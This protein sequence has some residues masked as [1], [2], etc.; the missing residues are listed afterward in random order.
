MSRMGYD[1]TTLG[2]HDTDLGPDGLGKAINVAAQA[3]PVPTVL[4]SNFNFSKDDATLADLQRLAKDGV[5]GE[6][7][8]SAA[9]FTA[10]ASG[11]WRGASASQDRSQGDP[12]FD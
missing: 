3:G 6:I 10:G 9:F 11:G 7:L 2:N 8:E 1:A 5:N 4:A 12:T